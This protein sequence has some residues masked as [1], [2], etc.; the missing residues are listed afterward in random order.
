MCAAA[1]FSACTTGADSNPFLGEYNTPHGVPPFN[2]IEA[3]HYLP[4][5]QEGV[6]QH[7]LE[8]DSIVQCPDA[9]T[10]ANTVEALEY[11]GQLLNRVYAVFMNLLD[12]ETSPDMDKVAEKVTAIVSKHQ[13]DVALN[14]KLFARIKAVY[15]QRESL[16]LEGEQLRLLTES[17]K[18]FVRGGANLAPESKAQLRLINDRL[19]SLELKF[20]QNLLGETNGFKLVVDN[21]AQLA[22]LPQSLCDVAAA[23][24]DS[25]VWT[26]TLK[27]PSI[28]PFLQYADSRDLRSQMLTAYAARGNNSNDK[29]NNATIAE[30][31]SLRLQK[32]QLFG[33]KV[34]ADYVLEDC[35][36]K[37]PD[38]VY[39]L[40]SEVWKP[41]LA[42]ARK[43]AADQ[44][45]LISKSDQKL[46]Q[47]AS[48]WRYYAEKIKQQSYALDDE[49]LRPYFKLENVRDGIF[50]LLNKLY[51]L[52]FT[53]V[54]DV[55]VYNKDVVC[56]AASE[57]NGDLLGLIYMDFFPRSGK[58]GG[59]WMTNYREQR[60][61]DGKR[62]VPVISLVFN[63]TP[64]VGEAPSLLT[65]DEVETFFHEFGHATHGLLSNCQYQ[66]LAGTNVPRDFV[67]MLSQILENWAFHPDMLALYAT[68][69]QTGEVIPDSL[70]QK[71]TAASH[72]G[73]GFQTV[74]YVAAAWLDMDYHTVQDTARV[75]VQGFE[76]ASMGKLG[77]ISEILPRY[78]STYFNHVFSS[79]GYEAGYYSYLWSEVLD[80]DGFDAFVQA[81][82]VFSK[83]VAASL[84]TNILERG[85][86]E[87]AMV[88]YKRFRG[89]EPSID[90]LLRRRGLK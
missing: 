9:P 16:Q 32:A 37:T 21:E 70:V 66:S 38:A 4:A 69:Y 36:A 27:N 29:D 2:K 68:H 33:H 62:V 75:D 52:T 63:F 49:Q 35:M 79:T 65:P 26:F 30:I 1:A 58:R 19:S 44:Q 8:I 25:G 60:Y 73:Q 71:I 54:T 74:E 48:D 64:T 14:D 85:N 78:R 17:Y 87:D 23:A 84:R 31:V 11:S 81:G 40:M 10:F 77:L 6:R 80:A 20:G 46:T 41:A 67:E 89:S 53:P 57:A 39:K 61:K 59:A 90:P 45:V 22:G 28:M 83:D 5:I 47:Q 51:G 86:T 3:R 56:F 34:Y 42:K 72:Y 50:T 82:D 55:P 76:Q 43:E 88:L 12:A 24:G 7:A 15:E 18:N 13:D